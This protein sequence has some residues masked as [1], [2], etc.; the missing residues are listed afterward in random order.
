ML[1]SWQPPAVGYLQSCRPAIVAAAAAAAASPPDMIRAALVV[2]VA[3]VPRLTRFYE[4]LSVEQQQSILRNAHRLV[5][6]R[7]ESYCAFVDEESLG[8]GNKLVCPFRAAS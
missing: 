4:A 8:A 5:V 6:D 2:N 3:G 7:L 1:L